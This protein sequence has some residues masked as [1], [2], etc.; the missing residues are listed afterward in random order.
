M[1][2]RSTAMSAEPLT[3][4]LDHSHRF[5]R[6][7]GFGRIFHPGKVSFREIA[8]TDSLHLII[9]KD[10]LSAHVDRISPLKCRNDGS[11]CYS[12][13]RIIAHNLAGVGGDV[14]R[15]LRRRTSPRRATFALA[16]ISDERS[17]EDAD[18]AEFAD[19]YLSEL[20]LLVGET[21]STRL[22]C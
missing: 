19:R 15:V 21:L 3:R 14:T 5:H 11:A 17:S 9:D 18:L 20:D 6:D 1:G 12:W 16:V 4:A 7:T 22:A 10:R 2:P 13:S 8:P